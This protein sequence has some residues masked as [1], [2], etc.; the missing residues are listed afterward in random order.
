MVDV[1]LLGLDA[2]AK[3]Q[4]I[5]I[6]RSKMNSHQMTTEEADASNAIL[7]HFSGRTG[8]SFK[9]LHELILETTDKLNDSN[10]TRRVYENII[11]QTLPRF[12]L[13]SSND[14]ATLLF[15]V[16]ECMPLV[17][18]ILK[19]DKVRNL[20][21]TSP[22]IEPI[23]LL[24]DLSKDTSIDECQYAFIRAFMKVNQPNSL[25][26]F[27]SVM[28]YVPSR[29][30]ADLIRSFEK[31]GI[32][33]SFQ[34]LMDNI[35]S[36]YIN[37]H[38]FIHK[39][40]DCEWLDAEA[41]LRGEANSQL[42]VEVIL[43]NEGAVELLTS[44]RIRL[45]LQECSA[46]YGDIIY[47]YLRYIK[48]Y[49]ELVALM[50]D[51]RRNQETD[52]AFTDLLALV[53]ISDTFAEVF[54][55]FASNDKAIRSLLADKA[56][57]I[58]AFGKLH[59]LNPELCIELVGHIHAGTAMQADKFDQIIQGQSPAFIEFLSETVKVA[60]RET[61]SRRQSSAD[62]IIIRSQK[63][64]NSPRIKEEPETQDENIQQLVNQLN[65]YINRVDNHFDEFK[66]SI[67]KTKRAQN[68]EKNCI[69]AKTMRDKLLA[70]HPDKSANDHI[71]EVFS[72]YQYTIR[73]LYKYARTDVDA[74][75]KKQKH[76]IRSDELN[77]IIKYAN[78]ITARNANTNHHKQRKR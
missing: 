1:M 39:Y 47:D 30:Q 19:Q 71:R 58:R 59:V 24:C 62:E 8:F 54:N 64:K 13:K 49:P 48:S 52:H 37:L 5:I 51:L 61:K 53:K 38:E 67:F 72:E 26:Q 76:S 12:T 23:K 32:T 29:Y 44:K 6:K 77:R 63:R 36:R 27:K 78:G 2:Q 40:K 46:V 31:T 56:S 17:K 75:G 7:N 4:I 45:S 65:T 69:I 16:A 66:H 3:R 55:K 74:N 15:Y 9:E 68:R 35:D 14:V 18:V 20:L 42:D 50:V 22:S 57:I 43:A 11:N 10:K 70:R 34:D 28:S 41:F 25:A 21:N 73:N 33:L 60:A